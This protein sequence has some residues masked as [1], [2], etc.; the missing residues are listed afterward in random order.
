MNLYKL[1][2]KDFKLCA[3]NSIKYSFLSEEKKASTWAETEKRMQEWAT[4]FIERNGN[5][6]S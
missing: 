3:Y 5:I 6:E 4:W 1:D 2:F